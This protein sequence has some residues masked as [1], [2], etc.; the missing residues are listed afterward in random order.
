MQS[1]HELDWLVVH[2]LPKLFLSIEMED[3]AVAVDLVLLKL[4]NHFEPRGQLGC[5][6]PVPLPVFELA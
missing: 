1:L 2:K 4:T 6:E 3:S 5:P